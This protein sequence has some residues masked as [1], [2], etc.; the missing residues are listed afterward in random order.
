MA[1]FA[2]NRSEGAGVARPFL[3]FRSVKAVRLRN[4][5]HVVAAPIKT[6]VFEIEGIDGKKFYVPVIEPVGRLARIDVQLKCLCEFRLQKLTHLE[7]LFSAFLPLF[8]CERSGDQRFEAS[9]FLEESGGRTG[10]PSKHHG[11]YFGLP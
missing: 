8:P 7:A 4:Y 11:R 9:L 6:T 3:K 2:C 1:P 5:D 10:N